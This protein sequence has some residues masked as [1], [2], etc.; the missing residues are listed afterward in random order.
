MKFPL[1]NFLQ[2]II[3]SSL[4]IPNI[5]LKGISERNKNIFTVHILV[6]PDIH[7]NVSRSS[8]VSAFL[9]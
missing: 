3:L 5:L 6:N 7:E 1:R 9:C 4:F 8:S 2:L